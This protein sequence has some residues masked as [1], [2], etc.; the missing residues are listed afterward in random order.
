MTFEIRRKYLGFLVPAVC[1]VLS[2]GLALSAAAADDPADL[3]EEIDGINQDVQQKKNDLIELNRKIEKYRSL[4]QQKRAE[5]ASLEDDIA[6]LENRI[7]KEQLAIDIAREEIKSIE[8][9][10]S[11]LDKRIAEQ[12]AQMEQ[13]KVLLGGLSRKL[14]RSQFRKSLLEIL[15]ANRTLSDFFNALHSMTKLQLAVDAS[16]NKIRDLRQ[17]LADEKADREAKRQ[18]SL[19]RKRSL[20][21]AKMELEDARALK[22]QILTETK[23]SELEYR[24][25]LADLKQEQGQADSEIVYLEK[26][27]RQKLS[28]AERIGSDS[29]VFSWP[30]QP[31]RGLS[32]L[33]HDPDYPF[34]YV[35]EHPAIDI[36]AGQG[37]VVR[38]VAA[39]I[40]A[41][42]KNAGMGYSYVMLLHNGDMS[43]VY[44]HLSKI[45]AKEDTFVERGEIIGYSGGMP[46][47]P[48]AGRMTT[49]PHLH[50]E[51]RKIGIPV[52]PLNYLMAY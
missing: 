51:V 14:Y 4:V 38:A 24:Y 32:S 41:R 22:D 46:G 18:T 33:F 11:I 21:V 12:E 13:E 37:T 39:G 16:L 23:S 45:V 8:L 1:L 6:L 35:F 9:E 27:L 19:D 42:A 7:A 36:R 25:L 48:G 28:L 20:E 17:D 49:G 31:T 43:T 30:L 44:G 26:V 52:D 2:A 29:A 3:R 5:S 10:I 40:V 47:T 50:F 34:R 15:L